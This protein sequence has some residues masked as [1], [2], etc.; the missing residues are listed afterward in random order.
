MTTTRADIHKESPDYQRFIEAEQRG[1]AVYIGSENA[2]ADPPRQRSDWAN[3]YRIGQE[4]STAGQAVKL[5][6]Q[7]LLGSPDLM[8][9][10]PELKD[11][12]L[13]CWCPAGAP[14]H[15]DVLIRLL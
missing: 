1:E 8:A 12:I 3:P 15:A 7:Y 6:E 14:C 4:A 10:L 5:Y 9:R 13:G 2:E 11:K